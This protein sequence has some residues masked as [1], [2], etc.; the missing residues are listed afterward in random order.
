MLSIA[1]ESD[2]HYELFCCTADVAEILHNAHA[3]ESCDVNLERDVMG[4]V[5]IEVCLFCMQGRHALF[6]H[7]YKLLKTLFLIL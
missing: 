5:Q 7:C 1:Q 6:G 4:H 3:S 2:P